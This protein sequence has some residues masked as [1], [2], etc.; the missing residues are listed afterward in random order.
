MSY[1]II[2]DTSSDV[3]I[4]QQQR[5]GIINVP[6]KITIDGVEYIDDNDL[7]MGA[8][9]DAMTKTNNAIVTSCP[10]PYDYQS[11]LE[12]V[13]EEEIFVV[14]IS[15]KLSGSHN[16][17][18]SAIDAFLR[19]HPEKKVALIDSKAASAGQLAVILK[20]QA[21]LSEEGTFDEHVARIREAV[22]DTRTFFILES[23]DNLIKNGRMKKTTGLVAS[24]LNIRPIMKDDNGEIA[25]HEINR[26]FKKSLLKLGQELGTL[27]DH[28]ED[29]VVVIAHAEGLEKAE[30]LKK[31]LEEVAKF[32]DVI[33]VRT[34]ALATGYADLGGIV[35]GV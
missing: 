27:V 9:V 5:D 28:V 12:T 21:I 13:E 8:F 3:S 18:H 32:K 1:K 23:F 19:A 6:F 34:K 20:M 10:S 7:D 16:A 17:A 2:T 4:A 30:F 35:I 31:K 29:R 25:L 24:A 33:I 14:T 11:V 22:E 15:S 26:G